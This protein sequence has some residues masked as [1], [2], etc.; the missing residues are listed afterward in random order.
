L[1]SKAL[2]DYVSD[3]NASSDD[4]PHD[5]PLEPTDPVERLG[6]LVGVVVIAAGH[7]QVGGAKTAQEQ[8]E[9]KV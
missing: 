4:G 6:Q 8:G 2:D 9:K 1:V 7:R 3:Q 5:P